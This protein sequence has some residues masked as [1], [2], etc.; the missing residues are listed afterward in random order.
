M[1]DTVLI[2]GVG[3]QLGTGL[4]RAFAGTGSNRSAG[5]A[6]T[7]SSATDNDHTVETD[8]RSAEAG[9]RVA[10]LARSASTVESVAAEIE[11][12]GG[13]ATAVTADL[14]DRERVADAVETVRDRFGPI[15]VVVHNASATGGELDEASSFAR[16]VRTR[17][18]GGG[19]L[20]ATVLPAM[21]DRGDGCLLFAGTTYA[22]DGSERLPGWGAAA[23]GTRGLA[24]SLARRAGPDGVHVCYVAVGGTIPPAD[25]QF[26]PASAMDPHRVG[27]AFRRLATQPKTAW[28]HEVDLRPSD[29]PP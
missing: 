3:E 20:A 26:Q 27:E 7:E 6:D 11:A 13:T 12:D 17:I 15:D 28:S 14:T 23:F 24:R 21:R 1:T 22:H 4:A 5:G 25:A 19:N 9:D 2:A 8:D 29:Y 10:L 16:P 18:E